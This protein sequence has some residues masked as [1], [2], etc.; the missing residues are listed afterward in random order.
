MKQMRPSRPLA[1]FHGIASDGVDR[2]GG[3]ILTGK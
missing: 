1:R 2:G 3:E